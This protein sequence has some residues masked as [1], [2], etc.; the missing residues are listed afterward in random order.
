MRRGV[1]ECLGS[2]EL[3]ESQNVHES[4]I[5]TRTTEIVQPDMDG[6]SAP[7]RLGGNWRWIGMLVER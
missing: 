3:C 5:R 4:K 2:R 1:V 6:T 7:I